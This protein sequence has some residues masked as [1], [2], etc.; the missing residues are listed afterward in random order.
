MA[1]D[2]ISKTLQFLKAKVDTYNSNV[3]PI[4]EITNIA[5][6]NDGDEYLHSTTPI[7]LSIVNI[8]EDT[9]AKVPNVYLPNTTQASSVERYKNPAQNLVISLLF[10][11]YNKEQAS[12]KYEDGLLKLEHVIRCFQEQHVFY[13]DGTT[14]VDPTQ[15]HIKIILDLESLKLSELNQLWSML[16]NKYM[17]SVLYKMRM[18]TIQHDEEDGGSTVERLRLKLWN[19]NPNDIAGQLEESDE[20]ILNNP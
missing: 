13:I 18:I 11:S 17:P 12:D 3:T 19:D 16:G 15:D 4:V 1:S 9:V 2:V 10:T 14:E 6:L 20:I 7:T 8:E 5:T